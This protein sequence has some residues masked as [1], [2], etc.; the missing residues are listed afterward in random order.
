[1][2]TLPGLA[3][4][5]APV[6]AAVLA[7]LLVGAVSGA[8]ATLLHHYWWGLALG[9]VA[10]VVALGWLPAGPV[11]LAFA[12]GWCLL[13]LRGA[14][15]R[16][17]GGFLVAGDAQGWSFLTGSFVLLVASVLTVASGRRRLAGPGRT[18]REDHGV[19]GSAT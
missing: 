11:R 9:L 4:K 16:P 15:P 14:L 18:R 6:L 8:A 13:A 10:A 12:L 1:M 7:A 17:G 19:R 2:R 5:R 3:A